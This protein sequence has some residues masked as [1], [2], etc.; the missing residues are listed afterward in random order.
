MRRDRP[1][2]ARW[3][4]CYL[5]CNKPRALSPDKLKN[6]SRFRYAFDICLGTTF[7]WFLLRY[8]GD[9]NPVWAIIS[10]IVV[11]DP[12]IEVARPAFLTRITHTL[13]GCIAGIVSLLI[14]G[15]ADWTLPIALTATALVCTL[16]T[17]RPSSWKLAPATAALVVAH[18]IV[19]QSSL[20]AL[21]RLSEERARSLSEVLPQ[22][23]SPGPLF[24]CR[25]KMRPLS[26]GTTRKSSDSLES[27]QRG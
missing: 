18:A 2:L 14:F 22:C 20:T 27:S 5:N 25:P 12:S 8:L 4:P 26:P 9:R 1:R 24:D 17:K 6:L 15:A 19:D 11:S 16:P 13:M 10:Y 23:S 7:L 3:L 21:E